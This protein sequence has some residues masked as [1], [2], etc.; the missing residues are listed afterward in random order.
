MPPNLFTGTEE[1]GGQIAKFAMPPLP[2]SRKVSDAR[3]ICRT[4]KNAGSASRIIDRH[5]T[6]G[7]ITCAPAALANTVYHHTRYRSSNT[8]CGKQLSTVNRKETFPRSE[9]IAQIML[10]RKKH[11]LQRST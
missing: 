8:E 1:G 11:L 2:R 6:A 3:Q 7:S 10:A 9:L 5:N 4:V